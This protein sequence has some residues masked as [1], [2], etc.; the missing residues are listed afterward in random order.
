MMAMLG[1]E[2]AKREL[3]DAP[4]TTAFSGD[5]ASNRCWTKAIKKRSRQLRPPKRGRW[6]T[7]AK[8]HLLKHR[9]KMAAE[10]ER[11]GKLD[12][13]AQRGWVGPGGDDAGMSIENGMFPL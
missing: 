5:G 13:W 7:E 12:G 10:L 2:W 8:H 6:A 9:P 11:Q 3:N 4:W 1:L